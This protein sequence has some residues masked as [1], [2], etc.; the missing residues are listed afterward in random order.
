MLRSLVCLVAF[1]ALTAAGPDPTAAQGKK[2][3]PR[4]EKPGAPKL[5]LS[6]DE[7]K[8]LELTNKERAKEKLPPLKPNA[9]LFQVARAHSANMA[10]KGEMN[11]VLDGKNPAQRTVAAGYNYKHVGEN[12]AV[13]D[14]APLAL[15]MEG[16]MK[17]PHHRENILKREFIEIGLGVGRNGKGDI[18]YTQLFGTPRKKR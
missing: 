10:K 18:Y 5:E 9:V 7:Q 16:W 2:E 6:A 14:G 11:H 12:V 13:S 3:S 15:I 8:L 1:L 4:E 17:S